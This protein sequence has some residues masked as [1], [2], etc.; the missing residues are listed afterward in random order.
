MNKFFKWFLIIGFLIVLIFINQES[1]WKF[2]SQMKGK[3]EN[4]D[5]NKIQY[6]KIAGTKFKVDLALT[7]NAREQGL[8]GR[9]ELKKNE[10]MLFV[11]NNMGKYS[12]WMK[13]MN[14]NIDIIWIHD[15]RKVVYIKQNALSKS[16]S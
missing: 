15:A 11:F 9:K 14:F 8:S 10:G 2:N 13:D 5:V 6:V 1:I 16:Y 4:L 12:F 3:V 7:P